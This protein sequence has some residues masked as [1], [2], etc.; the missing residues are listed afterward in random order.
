MDLSSNP[1]RDELKMLIL[2]LKSND[3]RMNKKQKLINYQS[4]G[5]GDNVQVVQKEVNQ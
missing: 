4:Q 1:T 5:Q 3:E 2:Q